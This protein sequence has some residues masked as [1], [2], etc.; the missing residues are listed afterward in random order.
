M[1]PPPLIGEKIIKKCRLPPT[2]SESSVAGDAEGRRKLK[3][4]SHRRRLKH[5]L[6]P[7]HTSNEKVDAFIRKKCTF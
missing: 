4:L 7:L 3:L 6:T 1:Q 5:R 2:I